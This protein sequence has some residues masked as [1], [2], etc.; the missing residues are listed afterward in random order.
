MGPER[1]G[2]GKNPAWAEPHRA[3]DKS[4]SQEAKERA[5]Q[6]RAHRDPQG[7]DF[8][9][10]QAISCKTQ[11]T[12]LQLW[13]LANYALGFQVEPWS[14]LPSADGTEL[15]SLSSGKQWPGEAM[16]TQSRAPT[17]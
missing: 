8:V 16:S 7:E 3:R 15:A 2:P 13:A 6:A 4:W 9:C 10:Q 11:N 14:Q 1:L 17:S 5:S 12:S